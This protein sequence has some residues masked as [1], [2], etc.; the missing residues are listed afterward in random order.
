[1]E[2]KLRCYLQYFTRTA[3]MF[4]TFAQLTQCTTDLPYSKQVPVCASRWKK[5]NKFREQHGRDTR[6]NSDATTTEML[7]PSCLVTLS[8]HIQQQN[9]T[10]FCNV[11][12]RGQY[13][14]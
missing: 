6:P 7:F 5:L 13:L 11:T 14:F 1:M 9:L 12:N 3:I 10:Y 4:T 2:I 8:R